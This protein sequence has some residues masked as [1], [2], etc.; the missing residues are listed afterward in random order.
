[1]DTNETNELD[2]TNQT[3]EEPVA[4]PAPEAPAEEPA[5]APAAEPAPAP[6]PAPEPAPAPAAAPAPAQPVKSD[7]TGSAFANLGINFVTALV[8][9]ITLG[10]AYPFMLCWKLKW[11]AKNTYIDGRRQTFDGNGGQLLGKY[12]LWIFLSIITFG[13]Y[14]IFCMPLNMNRW[15]T[16]HLHFEGETG[17]SK[18]DGS[19]WGL[20]GTKW[21]A[22]F[23]TIITLGLGAAWAHCYKQRWYTKHTIIDGHKLMFDGKGMQYFGKCILWALLSVIT[24]G[25][26]L[27]WR[28]VKEMKWTTSHTHLA[29]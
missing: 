24:L 17:E 29:A 6:A 8:S 20:F 11:Q 21:V 9:L 26:F 18:F 7:F 12:I 4:T 2:Q 10:I 28:A 3:N 13:I 14:A 16:K 27:I 19:I 22:N 1:M 5:P 15:V 23:V 25:I